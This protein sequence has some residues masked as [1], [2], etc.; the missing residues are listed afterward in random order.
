MG[1]AWH[2]K[3]KDNVAIIEFD[4][5][6]RDV[7]VLTLEYLTEFGG[8]IN[9]LKGSDQYEAL[10]ITSAK[11]KFFIAGADIKEIEKITT[12]KEAVDTAARG[13]EIFQAVADLKI[14]TAAVINGVCLGGGYELALACTYRIASDTDKVAIGLPEVKLGII[15]GF[16]R[17]ERLSKRFASLSCDLIV[18]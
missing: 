6:G 9:D 10:L 18:E 11:K 15:P 4:C 14:P 3:E 13:K 17:S 7:N 12:E 8:L 1:T 5:P 2:L 16:G